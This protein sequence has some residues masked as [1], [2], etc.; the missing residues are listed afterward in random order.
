MALTVLVVAANIARSH[1]QTS[2]LKIK[3]DYDHQPT[4][5][6]SKVVTDSILRLMPDLLQQQV[7]NVDLKAVSRA[8]STVPFLEHCDASMSVGGHIVVK[9][10]QRHPVAR[11]FAAGREFYI[12]RHGRAMPQSSLGEINA[13][14]ASG[15]ITDRIDTLLYDRLDIAVLAADSATANLG[16]VDI[17]KTAC[18][19]DANPNYGCLFDQ[20]FLNAAGDVVLTPKL[21]DHIVV[22][23]KSDN[24]DNKF[25]RLQLFY[26]KVMPKSGWDAYS[27][28][29]LKFDNQVVCTRRGKQ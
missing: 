19:L 12:D 22:L 23:G 11:V 8:A 24:L 6:D 5:V 17:W 4:L 3:I 15:N 28:L 25:A 14:V 16:I 1:S 29:N 10:S 21:G 7:R 18:Y 9:A 20:I 26:I 2:G 27:R 13:I